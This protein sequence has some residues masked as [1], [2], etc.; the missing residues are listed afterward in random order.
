MEKLKFAYKNEIIEMALEFV[1][2]NNLQLFPHQILSKLEIQRYNSF[3]EDSNRISYLL[4]RIS[5][6]QSYLK[7][8]KK[9]NAKSIDIKDIEILNGIFGQPFFT[10][11]SK[12][13]ISITHTTDEGGSIV[14]DRKFPMGIDAEK[15]DDNNINLF[16]VVIN[17]QEIFNIDISQEHLLTI[18]W[19]LKEAL[20]KATKL[21]FLI[22]LELLN[23]ETLVKT[24]KIFECTFKYFSQYKGV[25][26]IKN[27]IVIALAYPAQ[28]Q[29]KSM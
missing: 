11:D 15:I 10:F 17:K 20:V 23:I 14:F 24:E 29:I 12:I 28:L 16:N 13:D 8:I 21:G 3:M 25:A 1:Q 19:C 7:L 6:K 27:N 4:G 9:N 5:G 26:K 2:F 18:I 22:P